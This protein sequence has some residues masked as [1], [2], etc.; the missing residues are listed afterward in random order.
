MGWR[1]RL[2]MSLTSLSPG[3]SG[4]RHRSQA[5]ADCVNLSAWA[6]GPLCEE[7][8]GLGQTLK[9][10]SPRKRGPE[11]GECLTAFARAAVERREARF[12]DRKRKRH[13]HAERAGRL[14]QPLAGPRKARRFSALRPPR[15]FEGDATRPTLRRGSGAEADLRCPLSLQA[16]D[17]T[18]LYPRCRSMR[19]SPESPTES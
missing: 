9:A 2:R 8:A 15:L 19:I 10:S 6:L 13:A 11:P 16:I 5:C 3:G 18:T 14:R 12:L 7:L 1:R 17:L 4:H